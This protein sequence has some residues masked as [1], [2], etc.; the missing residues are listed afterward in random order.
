MTLI[1]I[2]LALSMMALLVLLIL[3]A[4]TPGSAHRSREDTPGGDTAVI[5]RRKRA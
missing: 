3:V 1:A 4:A 5:E 2:G